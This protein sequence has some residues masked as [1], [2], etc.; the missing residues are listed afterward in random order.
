MHYKGSDSIKT[1]PMAP[2]DSDNKLQNSGV[3][4][5][6]KCPHI[7][8]PGEY[9]GESGK[10]FEDR[11]NNHLSTP[12]PIH[13]HSHSTGPS[14]PTC[15]I[16]VD[17]ESQGVIRNIKEAMYIHVNDPSLNR[18]LGNYQLPHIWDDVLQ[19]TPSLQLK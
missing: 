16:I 17:R 8:C 11:L 1:L 10:S 14:K 4:Y 7:N 12:S 3:I 18:N 9:I 2:K 5:R 6:F 13:Q 15:F 19:D